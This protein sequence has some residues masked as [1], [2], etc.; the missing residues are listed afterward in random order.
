MATALQPFV[1][2]RRPT[3]AALDQAPSALSAAGAGLDRGRTLLAST[4]ALA[5]AASETLPSAPSGLRAATALLRSSRVPLSRTTALLRAANPAIPAT[6]RITETLSPVVDPMTAAF[7]DLAPMMSYIGRYGCDIKHFG[8]V[9]RSMTG[10]AAT[11]GGE[12]GPFGQFRFQLIASPAENAGI[13]KPG[14]RRVG[15]ASPCRYL[16]DS[17]RGGAP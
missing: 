6:L 15:Y 16:S 9:F 14:P 1:D 3:R 13:E 4:R 17:E 11:P 10:I 7:D 5:A 8:A 12:A 2:R